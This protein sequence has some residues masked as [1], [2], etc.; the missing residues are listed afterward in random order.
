MILFFQPDILLE[1]WQE[2]TW[3]SNYQRLL[4]IKKEI[5]PENLFIVRQGVNSEGWDYESVC[6]V[7]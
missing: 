7:E 6:K 4:A 5:D 2:A 3:G 1:N